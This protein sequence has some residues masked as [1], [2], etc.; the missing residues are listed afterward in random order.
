MSESLKLRI[1]GHDGRSHTL[2]LAGSL[3]LGRQRE[4][5]P[6]PYRS[7]PATSQNSA[8]LII[9]AANE[10]DNISRQ[11]ALLEPLPSG[12]VRVSNR[13]QVLDNSSRIRAALLGVPHQC[14]AMRA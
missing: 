2:D 13:R 9:A 12:N 11:H 1:L 3:E 6:E 8:R 7:V 10:K 4:G 5:E 14:Q